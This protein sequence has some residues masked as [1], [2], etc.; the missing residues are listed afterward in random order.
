MKKLFLFLSALLCLSTA[1]ADEGMWLLKLMEQQHLTDSLR[2]AGL[3]LAPEQLYSETAT[4]LRD[5]VGIFGN[6]CTGEIISPNGL[7]LTNN[8]CGFDFVHAMS[9]MQH[10]YLQ[11]GF[12]AKK[13]G[14]ELAVRGLTFTFVRRIEDV[15]EKVVKEAKEKGI[16]EY[17][18]QSRAFLHPL[19]KRLLAV[20]DMKDVPGIR[21]RL[22][23]FFGGNQF[24]LFFEQGFEDVRL[25]ANPPQSVAQFGF[26]SDNWMWPRHNA[27]FMVFRIYADANGNPAPYSEANRP[28]STPKYLPISLKGVDADDYTMVM[29]FPGTTTRFLTASQIEMRTKTQ[30]TP[31]NMVGEVRL[32]AMKEMMNADPVLNLKLADEYMSQGNVVK[33]Y[34]GMNESVRRRGLVEKRAA[35]EVEFR[36]WARRNGTPE[37]QNIIERIDAVT[38]QYADSLYDLYLYNYTFN[39]IGFNIMKP[40]LDMWLKAIE[41]KDEKRIQA[42]GKGLYA[43]LPHSADEIR[44]RRTLAEQ[45]MPFWYKYRRLT[46][47]PDCVPTAADVNPFLARLFTESLFADSVKFAKFLAKPNAKTLKKDPVYVLAGSMNDV[48]SGLADALRNY[49]HAIEPLEKIYVRALC[50]KNNWT[51]APDANFTL[52]MTYGHVGGY[53][54]RDAVKYDFYTTLD[55][56]LEKENPAD[57]DYAIHPRLRQLYNAKDFGPYAR[58]DGKLP[59]CFITNNDITGGNS[60]SPVMNADGE[61][62]GCAFDGNIES[63]SSD[64]EFDPEMQ[65]CINV[66]VRY[67]LWVLDNFGGSKYLFNELDL[68]K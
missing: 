61:L 42:L 63:L 51:K 14:D 13:Q 9:T 54:P 55:G 57:P 1:R 37:Y 32:K 23:P 41:A 50:E 25:V 68:R 8:H 27:D 35:S 16:D 4:S 44:V 45:T 5:A 21:V 6:G 66:D 36:E 53:S 34:G 39:R 52:R 38:K 49:N 40:R 48:I 67:I 22:V 20:S 62:I 65:R 46:P 18:M 11:D 43:S 17:T 26:N 19:S 7:I 12:F 15:T 64:L 33:N 24:Y 59:T 3:K 28:L 31:I 10:N 30:N 47:S 56:M 29:G 2:K 58:E 60:G